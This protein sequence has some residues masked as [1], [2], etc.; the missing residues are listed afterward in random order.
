MSPSRN[1][2]ALSEAQ[3]AQRLSARSQA[4]ISRRLAQLKRLERERSEVIRKLAEA[5]VDLH[6]GM[7]SV[8]SESDGGDSATASKASAG[9]AEEL[10][11]AAGLAL[12]CCAEAKRRAA[13]RGRGRK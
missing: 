10:C 3:T 13:R 1:I 11:S 7:P 4:V 2:R 9:S 5:G 12:K 6:L 8:E